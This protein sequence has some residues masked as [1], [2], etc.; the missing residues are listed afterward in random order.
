VDIDDDTRR[1]R[2]VARHVRFGKSEREARRWVDD[3]DEANARLIRATRERADLLVDMA[4][5]SP[6]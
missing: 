5:M 3:V 4:D 6:A 2:L 1:S